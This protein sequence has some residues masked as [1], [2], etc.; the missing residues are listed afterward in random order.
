MTGMTKSELWLQITEAEEGERID[1]QLSR[2]IDSLSRSYLQKL[3]KDEA[4][5]LE[6]E[7]GVLKP[8]KANYRVKCDDRILVAVPEAVIPD[9]KPENIDLDI[10]FEDEDLLA[11]NKPQGMVVHPA[12]GHYS[13][14]L[15]NALMYHCQNSLSGINGVLRP[16]IVHR[17][18]RDTTGALLVCKNN[19]AHNEIAGQLMDHSLERRYVAVVHGA[20]DKEEDRIAAPIGRH[21][22]DRKKMTVTAGGKEAITHYRVLQRLGRYTYIE[23]RLETGRT[24]QI[25]VHMSHIGHP[26]VGD[27]VYGRVK[28]E[29][30]EL[31]RLKG[32]VLHAQT[33]G[34][35]HPQSRRFIRLVAPLPEY[36]TELL[37]ALGNRG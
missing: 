31:S 2:F 17:I 4:V 32:Q 23:C 7:P 34:F 11:V 26:V 18:D 13:G 27:P 16:G 8:V 30:G 24:H 33:L 15:V 29:R 37:T 10:L 22:Q 12:P 1:K 9:I 5:L 3:L 20:P 35:V 28:S 14:T 19:F 21:K 36:F 25:R 6:K